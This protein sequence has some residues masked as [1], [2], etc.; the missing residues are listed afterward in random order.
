MVLTV[1]VA[2]AVGLA[3]AD[4]PAAGDHRR[5]LEFAGKSRPYVVHVPEGMDPAGRWPV[6]LA[7]HGF[8]MPATLMPRFS[9]LSATAD[10]RRFVV[11]YPVG[12]GVPVRW[13]AFTDAE[14]AADDVGYIR[15][16]L[17]DLEGFLPVDRRRVYAT[18]MSNGGMMCYRL[19]SELSDRIAAVAPVAGTMPPRPAKPGRAVPL[20]HVH[21]TEDEIVPYGGPK[22]P[23]GGGFAFGSVEESARAWV[24]A[25]GCPTEGA[26]EALPD[27]DAGDGCTVVRV[28]YGPGRV[29][30]EVVVYKVVGGGHTWPGREPPGKFLGRSTRDVDGGELIWEFFERHPMPETSAAGSG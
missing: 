25:N 13:N 20:L 1:V 17:D 14:G 23:V 18:G 28:R 9:G 27:A 24:E 26:S 30:S 29:G 4:P 21:G 11:A 10:A 16:V 8:A 7:L 5:P 19:A 15:A 12:T 22:R 2:C 3:A 6:V